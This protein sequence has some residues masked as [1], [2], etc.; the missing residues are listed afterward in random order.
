MKAISLVI[1][2]LIYASGSQA[3]EA[4]KDHKSKYAGQ[5]TRLIKSLSPEDIAELK[6]GGGW[7]LAKAAELNGV[8]GPVHLLEMKDEIPLDGAQITAI[9]AVYN[10]MKSRAIGQGEKLIEL[11]GELEKHF[12]ARTITE[13][14]LRKSLKAIAAVKMELRYTHL[15]THLKTPNIL[16]PDQIT[17]YNTL[18][19]YSSPDPCANAPVGHDAKMWRKHNGCE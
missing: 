18:R 6:R 16:T 1:P 13:P 4:H 11:E 2:F 17:K 7:G 8:P 19:G 3:V 15:A 9:Q 10:E 14:I 12:L 5:E